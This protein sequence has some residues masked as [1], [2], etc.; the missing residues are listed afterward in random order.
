[1]VDVSAR[2]R[3]HAARVQVEQ[4]LAGRADESSTPWFGDSDFDPGAPS[5]TD[6][7]DPGARTGQ[8]AAPAAEPWSGASATPDEHSGATG[9]FAPRV[10]EP[11]TA[12]DLDPPTGPIRVVPASVESAGSTAPSGESAA[13]SALSGAEATTGL[14]PATAAHATA[15]TSRT[16]A[17]TRPAGA[18]DEPD[19]NRF[20]TVRSGG[21]R[22]RA[23]ATTR[24]GGLLARATVLASLLVLVGGGATA[25]A[26]DKTVT[27]V[28]DGSERTVHTFAG[29]VGSALASAGMAMGPHDR[30][31]PAEPT[32]L[33]DGDE[34]IVDRARP[35]TLVEGGSE[36][37][38]W[39]TAGSVDEALKAMGM[40]A[41]PAQ[42]S[43]APGAIIPLAGMSLELKVPHSVTF[44]D[45]TAPAAPVTTMA[46]T[47]SGLLGEKGVKLGQDDVS[48]PSGDT[49]LAD[50]LAV[51]VVRNGTGEVVE[52]KQIPPPEQVVEDPT[53]PR[54]ERQVM[55]PGQPGEQT[56]VMRVHVQNGQEM[57]REQ[58]RAFGSTPPK[59]RVVKV[60][61]NDDA[62]AKGE[63][64]K[65]DAKADD[66]SG[67]ATAGG[68]ATAPAVSDGATWDKLAQCESTGNWAINTG[69]GYYGG[70]QFDA[71]TW[72]AYGGTA[73][74]PL[75]H[76]ASREEQIAV[77][78][79]VRDD[80]GGYGAWPACAKKLG[81]P[82]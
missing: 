37:Q 10:P 46:G 7:V 36:R 38:I 68:G 30:V 25:L 49:P 57:S 18:A 53:M 62:P 21:H 14:H 13:S 2:A 24:T 26:M 9:R 39:T 71:G 70:V 81:L 1:V 80:R 35:L 76:Q 61:T 78:S 48:I 79:K 74:A 42:L 67:G 51:Q 66:D 50:G 34:I 20:P 60:G 12:A 40:D 45:G 6:R 55:D 65:P 72:K 23:P 58:V 44:A 82:R 15:A 73:Y 69:N 52:T 63:D 75:P 64:A 8:V 32:E 16:S 43:V 77:A 31:S 41:A 47:V 27:L 22:R 11:R 29:D 28:V 17:I 59:P 3:R 33:D 54:G 56:A 19:T 4:A 5:A